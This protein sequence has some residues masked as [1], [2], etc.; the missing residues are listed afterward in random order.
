MV[1]LHS[2]EGSDEFQP[3]K[4]ILFLV[5]TVGTVLFLL[6]VIHDVSLAYQVGVVSVRDKV[7]LICGRSAVMILVSVGD[8]VQAGRSVRVPAVWRFVSFATS[9]RGS[10]TA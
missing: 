9:P 4:S 10:V 8:H 6:V 2:C 3:S 5:G 1:M 7:N